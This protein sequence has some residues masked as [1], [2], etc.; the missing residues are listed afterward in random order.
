MFIQKLPFRQLILALVTA[1]SQFVHGSQV[2]NARGLKECKTTSLVCWLRGLVDGFQ[3]RLF[4]CIPNSLSE[5]SS[6]WKGK[7]IYFLCLQTKTK[8]SSDLNVILIKS[9]I[10]VPFL[11]DLRQVC[12]QRWDSW[13]RLC[14]TSIDIHIT[15]C[16]Q[17]DRDQVQRRRARTDRNQF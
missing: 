5:V 17:W 6:P 13:K 16:T 11:H 7:Y 10:T 2:N 8:K 12:L 9:D 4:E 1:W 14:D 3:H 15:T